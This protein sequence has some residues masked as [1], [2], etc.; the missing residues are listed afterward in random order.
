MGSAWIW[1]LGGGLVG[2]ALRSQSGEPRPAPPVERPEDQER[3]RQWEQRLQQREAELEQ[4]AQELAGMSPDQALQQLLEDQRIRQRDQ[5]EMVGR[6]HWEE[7]ASRQI[8]QAMQRVVV[9]TVAEHS[10]SSVALP[11]EDYKGR[12]IGKEGRN[13]R[14]FESLTGVDVVI[15]DTPGSVSLSCFDPWRREVARV[16]LER[17][18][19]DGRFQPN[20]IE[21]AVSRARGEMEGAL[22]DKGRQAAQAVGLS[23]FRKEVLEGLGRLAFRTSYRQNALEHSQE[24]AWL[25][26][27]LASELGGDVNVCKRAGLLHDIGKGLVGQSGPHALLGGEF[28]RRGGES[29]AVSHAVEAHHEDVPQRSLEATLVQVADAISA[30]RPG[31][32]RENT[33]QYLQRLELLERLGRELKGVTDCHVVQAGREIRVFVRPDLAD[34]EQCVILAQQL[35]TRIE[36]ASS[37]PG[38]VRV[39]IV[40]HFQAS[41]QTG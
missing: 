9:Q 13:L 5:I 22:L 37:H 14:L 28:C 8:S 17:L 31:A 4:R 15:D 7:L 3:L 23:G 12:I 26:A 2:A 35:A 40:R 16:A 24:V 29:D 34:D 11:A 10:L 27:H 6:R 18:V 21:E 41:A 30:A 33:Q 32:R 1:L 25:C 39:T 20:R 36:S 19:K 38:P